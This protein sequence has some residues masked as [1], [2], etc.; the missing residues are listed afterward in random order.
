MDFEE[1]TAWKFTTIHHHWDCAM[2]PVA[3]H[4]KFK[5]DCD[6]FQSSFWPFLWEFWT[7]GYLSWNNCKEES[8]RAEEVGKP[9]S[10]WAAD[11][12][13]TPVLEQ[14]CEQ[15]P[16]HPPWLLI[17]IPSFTPFA[18]A[19]HLYQTLFHGFN[20]TVETWKERLEGRKGQWGKVRRWRHGR[21]NVSIR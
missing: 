19:L 21:K 14:I 17:P 20:L 2:P 10:R 3:A 13:G 12:Q 5:D 15:A 8:K 11:R 1:Q 4:V 18:S 9:S 16:K 6:R 7:D